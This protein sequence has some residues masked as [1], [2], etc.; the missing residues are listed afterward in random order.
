MLGG[1]SRGNRHGWLGA[2]SCD[3]H[4][5]FHRQYMGRWVSNVVRRLAGLY[6]ICSIVGIM[7]HYLTE[8]LSS[9]QIYIAES[10][11]QKFRHSSIVQS[12]SFSLPV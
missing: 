4:R 5:G 10:G 3:V 9:E 6:Y 11:L 12:R 1:M 7:Y 2:R 8:L